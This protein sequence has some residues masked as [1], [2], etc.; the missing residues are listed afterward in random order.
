M[1]AEQVVFEIRV[2][3]DSQETPEAAAALLAVFS[4]Y[5]TPFF[6]ALLGKRKALALEIALDNQLVHFYA[7][8]AAEIERY[9]FSQLIAQYPKAMINRI[10]DYLPSWFFLKEKTPQPVSWSCGQLA[11]SSAY[12]LPLKTYHD[13]K[14]V[15]PLSSLLGILGKATPADKALIQLVLAPAPR[16]YYSSAQRLLEKGV[17]TRDELG[18][19]HTKAHPAS[20]LINQKIL[21]K[22]FWTG[23]RLLTISVDQKASDAFLAY[24]AGAFGTF[25][26]GEGNSLT[27]KKPK[28]FKKA[29][30]EAILARRFYAVPSCQYLNIEEL[31]TLWHL[32]AEP[33]ARLKNIAWGGTF[34]SE[35]PE[36]L[37]VSLGLS[38]AQKREINFFAKTEFRN[39]MVTFGIKREDRRKH[40]YLIGKTGTGKSTLIANM[41]I[42]DIRHGEGVAVIDP[43]GDLSEILLDYIPAARINDVCYLDPADT[44]HPFRLNIFEVLEPEHAEL[45]ASG[46]VSIFYKLYHYSWGPRL[47]YILRNT[48]LTLLSRPGSTLVDVPRLLS[49]T[50]FRERVVFELK[51]KVLRSFWLNEF[52]KM[53]EKLRVEAISP[54]LNKVG[55]FVS[56]PTIRQIIGFEH[57]T[58]DLTK[59]M[60]ERKI[61]IVNLSQGRLGED[62]AALLGAM[63]I[64]KIQLSAMNRVKMAEEERQDFYL[65]V[66]E[67]QNFATSS[68]VKILSEARKYRLN[69]TVANQYI[70]QLTEEVMKAIFGNVGSLLSFIVGASDARFL[71]AEFGETFEPKDLVSLGKYQLALKLS[72]DNLTSNPFHA[73]TLPLPKCR[74]KNRDKILR[75]SRERYTKAVK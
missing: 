70:G 48:I 43:H 12:Y 5:R 11:L 25:T 23:I 21:H 18:R 55:Q 64:T 74:N 54:I 68:F 22:A 51:D 57:S 24:L 20:R 46:I 33:L 3:K 75:V 39:Q 8:V 30:L 38:E 53:S 49:E 36:N 27:L 2:P 44:R 67:F 41:A 66:D 72:I 63:F 50:K 26:L 45:V 19:F 60:D 15:D 6:Q 65:Y 56:S 73:F 59:I 52:N 37:P 69:L 9:F 29:L 62:N 10:K 4:D 16:S 17:Q 28:L 58:V 61:L 71:A 32:P 7:V 42:N 40:V 34:L 35:A 13:F 1:V 31:A 14:E 47:E